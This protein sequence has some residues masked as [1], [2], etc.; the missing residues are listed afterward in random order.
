M[1]ELMIY[2]CFK[3]WYIFLIFEVIIVGCKIFEKSVFLNV[4]YLLVCY[5]IFNVF[6]NDMFLVFKFNLYIVIYIEIYCVWRG[7]EFVFK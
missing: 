1:F 2:I 7:K 6:D 3:K 4:L 5:L